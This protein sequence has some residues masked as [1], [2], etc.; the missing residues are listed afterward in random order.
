MTVWYECAMRWGAAAAVFILVAVLFA[1]CGS[2]PSSN[3]RAAPRA[4]SAPAHEPGP[5]P[6]SRPTSA[7]A[8]T[9]ATAEAPA[10][11]GCL[12]GAHAAF[13]KT[14]LSQLSMPGSLGAATSDLDPQSFDTHKDS[15]CSDYTPSM[16]SQGPVINNWYRAQTETVTQQLD[17]GSRFVELDVG[18]NGVNEPN[19]A[20]RIDDTLYS[21]QPLQD[22]LIEVADWAHAHPSEVVVVGIRRVCQNG[23]SASIQRSLWDDVASDQSLRAPGAGTSLASVMYDASARGAPSLGALT[24]DDVV[25][26]AKGHH[27]VVLVVPP[28][29][30]ARAY[31]AR[32][33]PAQPYIASSEPGR[34][35]A[36]VAFADTGV[37]PANSSGYA[38]ANLSIEHNA[39]TAETPIGSLAGLGLYVSPIAY[40]LGVTSSTSAARSSL[41]GSFGGLV[42]GAVPA[43]GSTAV[44]PWETGLWPVAG[45]AA[46]SA[47]AI[48]MSWGHRANIVAVD[49]LGSSGIVST[50]IELN[51]S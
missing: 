51:G 39:R 17:E 16:V 13:G 9:C 5:V 48:A 37:A 23:A 32:T 45:G 21:E 31:G 19:L 2:S 14:P 40:D 12:V 30:P 26:S 27:N 44:P 10:W 4:S 42:T 20:W 47:P 6:L 1:A 33:L 24:I 15:A 28:G 18:F 7:Q 22:Y 11:E 41:Y 8:A 49:A 25:H 36:E 38:A 3:G 34:A 50:V 46:P 43:G 29:M 35:F